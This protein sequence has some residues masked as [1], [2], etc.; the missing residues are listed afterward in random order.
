MSGKEPISYFLGANTAEGFYSLYEEFADA[1]SGDFVWYIKG[2]PGNGKSTFM[3][4]A[5]AAAEA[6]GFAVEYAYC[7]G[8]PDS[9]D[10][11]YI[12]QL[13]MAYV[14]ATAPHVQ[15]PELF[16]A[17]GRYI[18]LSAFYMEN[19]VYDREAIREQ[20][21]SYRAQYARAYDLFR[22][23]ALSRPDRIPGLIS[24]EIRESVCEAGRDLAA[25]HLEHGAGHA[26]KRR[27]ISAYT[28]AGRVFC[29]GLLLE[30]ENVLLLR[31]A[32]YL[33]NDYLQGVRDLC[34]ERGYSVILFPEALCPSQLEGLCVPEAGLAICAH[35]KGL[36]LPG[37]Q[38][39]TL[40]LDGCIPRERMSSC[41]EEIRSGKTA[42]SSLTRQGMDSLARAK[43][44]HDSLEE[45]YRPAVD[46]ESLERF[47]KK[48]IEQTIGA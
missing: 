39:K 36:V 37:V 31:S 16:G 40:E 33:Q 25:R 19:A 32:L 17:A 34:R 10:G 7:S 23:A 27:F 44:L 24:E 41:S 45:L 38:V 20:S 21:A 47:C 1:G 14:D 22:A 15:E 4:R 28:C 30:Q 2:G 5:A 18:D 3:R 9:L 11:I 6:K 13:H 48:H 46:F 35:R 12:R 43:E 42:C 8:D 26:E 29:P